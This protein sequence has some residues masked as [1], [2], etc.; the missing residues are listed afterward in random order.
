MVAV[1]LAVGALTTAPARAKDPPRFV[2]EADAAG[3]HHTYDGDFTYFVGG[4]V[5]AFDCDGDGR[6][7]LYFAGG[8]K[9]AGLYRNLSP[10]GGALR[11]AHVPAPATDLTE[12]VGA[13][14]VN[15]DG[16][17]RTDLV[18]LRVG[19]DVVL[20]GVGDCRFE[21]ANERWHIDGGDSWTAAF[22]A[23]WEGDAAL[24]TLAFGNYLDLAEDGDVPTCDD[25]ALVR[26]TKGGTTYA[27]PL[28]LEPGWCTLSILFSDWSRTGH[29]DLRMS[30]DRHYSV[31]AEEQLWR[32][33]PGDTPHLYAHEEGWQRLPIWGMGI[34]SYDVTGDGLPEVYL[35]SQADNKLQTLANGPGE[36]NYRDIAL[37]R[38]VTAHRPYLGGDELPST[39][40]HPEFQ[41]VNND[42]FIDLFVSKGNVDAQPDFASKDPSDLLMGQPNGTFVECGGQAGIATFVRG[43]GAALV[44]LNLDGMLDLLQVN[45]R[46]NVSVWRNIGWGSADRPTPMGNWVAVR[47]EQ[48]GPNRD[49]IGSWVEVRFGDRTAEREVTVGGGHASGQLGWIHFGVGDA[50]DVGIRV[51]WPDGRVGPWQELDANSWATIE[52][53]TS[54]P[55]VWTPPR[56]VED[57]TG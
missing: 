37:R 53:G 48:P 6:P 36:P 35:T 9:P 57:G 38:G 21:R 15:I 44:D 26:P 24:P 43:R 27:E 39:A 7:D 11:F 18:V 10:V 30:N 8:T 42:G 5:A 46:V 51:R 23:T 28:P 54:E 22:S 56:G 32:M 19:E 4:G 16:D 47:L 14:P 25:S 50:D 40:W 41:D 20:R 12:V 1:W 31:D 52:R 33:E 17:D 55:A 13:Y 34:A 2:D 29:A 3:I 49:G 45:R